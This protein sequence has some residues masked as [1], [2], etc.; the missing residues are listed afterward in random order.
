MAALPLQDD[1]PLLL[2]ETAWEI[3]QAVSFANHN[4]GVLLLLA[5]IIAFWGVIVQRATARRKA[6]LEF[7][8]KME[9]DNDFL[10]ANR[11]FA[12][13]TRSDN[14]AKYALQ[15]NVDTEEAQ[16]IK[17]VLNQFELASVGIQN[18]ILDY[19]MF[20]MWCRGWVLETYNHVSAFIDE[21]RRRT[22]NDNLFKEFQYLKDCLEKGKKMRRRGK[23]RRIVERFRET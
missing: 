11:I 22:R 13:L 15:E 17:V 5:G 12:S 8:Q 2:N 14:I 9:A 19:D 7:I 4:Q 16:A 23:I 18:G 21:L 1:S 20:K 10:Q 6:T 3:S